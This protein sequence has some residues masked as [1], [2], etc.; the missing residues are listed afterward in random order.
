[1]KI[2]YHLNDGIGNQACSLIQ[3]FLILHFKVGG[4]GSKTQ[5]G[6]Q[7]FFIRINNTEVQAGCT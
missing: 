3:F 1:M 5:D 4:G 2:D 6:V 7:S